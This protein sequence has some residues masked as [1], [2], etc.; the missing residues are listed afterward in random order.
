MSG[1]SGHLVVERIHLIDEERHWPGQIFAEA[2]L[3]YAE[4]M[5]QYAQAT[6]DRLNRSRFERIPTLQPATHWRKEWEG[7]EQ[8]YQTR[9]QRKQE[10]LA[11]Q[12]AKT[13]WRQT[14]QGYQALTRPER[15]EQR[16][17]YQLAFQT[18]KKV[19]QQHQE[20]LRK[21]QE[22]DQAW[23]QR[24]QERKA[25]SADGLQERSWIAILVATDN[26]T[27][28]CLGL[29]LFRTGPNVTSVEVGTALQTIL[30]KDL[31]F[32]ISDQ[33]THFRSRTFVILAKEANFI[34]VPIYR[35][36]PESNGIAE[37]FVLTLKNWLRSRSWDSPEKVSTFL[38]EFQRDYND[39]PHQGLAIPGLSPNEFAN[40]I[41][42]M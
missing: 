41:W 13:E 20:T 40:R 6:Q 21:W 24:N 16:F 4:A 19:R 18:W 30:P 32:L 37:R 22:E 34:H 10:K 26:C 1:S 9:E 27:R 3:D 36:R 17:A 7:R 25:D 42:L 31:E 35:H 2:G 23:H 38:A 12:T 11:W 5:R 15:T 33:G 8:R 14:R 29:P 39:R 28:Q